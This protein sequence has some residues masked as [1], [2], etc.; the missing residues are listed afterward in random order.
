MLEHGAIV[1]SREITPEERGAAYPLGANGSSLRAEGR[2]LP[3]FAWLLGSFA[4]A[5]GFSLCWY[6]L[7]VLE[8]TVLRLEDRSAYDYE[9]GL[10]SGRLFDDDA[11]V[12]C[13]SGCRVA[14]L[15]VE[16]AEDGKL[17]T[18]AH[19]LQKSLVR[20]SDRIY[21]CGS[22]SFLV[23]LTVDDAAAAHW[24]A[25]RLHAALASVQVD[26]CIGIAFADPDAPDTERH[27]RRTAARL[28]KLAATN[29]AAAKKQPQHRIY[30]PLL[31]PNDPPAVASA[32]APPQ[33]M[34]WE[35][36]ERIVLG[37]PV[38]VAHG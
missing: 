31:P 35:R 14:V 1:F 23:L 26:G 22:E 5:G 32:V 2:A 20:Q 38:G 30:P 18:A 27:N 7:L 36:T 15:L 37:D 21:R 29:L 28:Q 11:A 4:V 24:Q 3:T 33:A 16:V 17:L 8:R 25:Q 13:R 10:R 34:D 19:S 12:L 6:R 9:T